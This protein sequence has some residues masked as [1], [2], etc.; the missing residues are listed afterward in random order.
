MTTRRPQAPRRPRR[1]LTLIEI[2]IAIIVMS[3]GVMGLATTAS[4]VAQQMGN[5]NNQTIAASLSTKVADS[6]SSRKCSSLV[7]GSQ[8]T[9]GV[10]VAWTVTTMT[11]TKQVDQTV[12]YK[13]KRGSTKTL[14]YRMVVQCPE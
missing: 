3:I 8:T 13:P 5:G 11:R 10:T 2:I 4:Y 12:T 14:S 6:L 9:R 7:S 1:G